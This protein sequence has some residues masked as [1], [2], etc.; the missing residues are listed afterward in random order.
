[1]PESALLP[2]AILDF[3]EKRLHKILRR[4]LVSLL[5]KAKSA[6]NNHMFYKLES[7]IT[8][9]ELLKKGNGMTDAIPFP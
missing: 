3:V 8:V 1:M 5:K 9:H 2:S 6:T 4:A 7:I